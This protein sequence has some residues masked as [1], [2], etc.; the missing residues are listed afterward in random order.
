MYDDLFAIDNMLMYYMAK[1]IWI[2]EH[3]YVLVKH[4]IDASTWSWSSFAAGT[5]SMP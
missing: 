3:T 5:G 4:L 2:P 1:G